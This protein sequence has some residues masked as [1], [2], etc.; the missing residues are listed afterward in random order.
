MDRIG[1]FFGIEG[2]LGFDG[3]QQLFVSFGF[4][5][6]SNPGHMAISPAAEAYTTAPPRP[7]APFMP[8]FC[9]KARAKNPDHVPAFAARLEAV[10]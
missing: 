3:L 2:A 6:G 5:D 10:P 4:W 7:I 9:W 8:Q 1:V